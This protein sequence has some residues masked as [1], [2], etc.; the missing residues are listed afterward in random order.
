MRPFV[1][2]LF[3]ASVTVAAPAAAQIHVVGRSPA[4]ICFENA[5]AARSDRRA[6]A[7]CDE[8]LESPILLRRDVAATHVNRGIILMY[9]G[10]S[11]DAL[12]AYDRAEALGVSD[13]TS[14][15]L[16]RSSALI[17]LERYAAAIRQAEL[18]TEA[19]GRHVAEA[20]LN[21][22]I[23]HE[24]LGELGL[25]YEAYLEALNARPDWHLA[26]RQVAR[27]SVTPAS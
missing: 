18:V 8:A 5:V 15:A 9:R 14:L 16:N 19:G 3:L 25:A 24:A 11:E 4:A 22:G 12:D 26:Q 7:D 23:A 1:S 20:W 2:V 17:R 10:Q 27:F 6:L 13:R 21:R